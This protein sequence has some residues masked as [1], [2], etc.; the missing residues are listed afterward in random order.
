MTESLFVS[1]CLWD[2]MTFLPDFKINMTYE[3]GFKSVLIERAFRG[4]RLSTD[5]GVAEPLAQQGCYRSHGSHSN[6][7]CHKGSLS[8]DGICQDTSKK[9]VRSLFMLEDAISVYISVA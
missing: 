7:P 3:S 6:F 4:S 8:I 9:L 1:L 5:Y 2:S